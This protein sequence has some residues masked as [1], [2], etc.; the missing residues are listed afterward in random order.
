MR[1]FFFENCEDAITQMESVP[2]DSENADDVDTDAEDHAADEIRYG[3]QSRPWIEHST[4]P[5]AR[6]STILTLETLWQDEEERLLA[7]PERID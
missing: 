1:I 3:V 4:S 2:A 6:S 5:S 7:A